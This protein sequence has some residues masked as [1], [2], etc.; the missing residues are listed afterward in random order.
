[1]GIALAN[2]RLADLTHI[3]DFKENLRTLLISALFVLLAAR[4]SP[5]DLRGLGLSSV[6]VIALLMILIR[7]ASVAV[8]TLRSKLTWRERTFIGWMAPRGIVAAAVSSVFALR[9][10]QAGVADGGV[11]VPL[12]FA[13]I[14]AT[15]LVYGLTSPIVAHR[16]KL[17]D[18]KPQG[19]LIVGAHRAAREIALAVKA[20]GFRV[21]LVDSNA[22]DVA[23]ARLAG[24]PTYHGSIL[25]ERTIEQLDLGGIGQLLAMTPNEEVNILAVQR[26][27]PIF[28]RHGV[29]Q[30][31]AREKNTQLEGIDPRLH[32]RRL[33]HEKATLAEL[34]ARLARGH[35]VKSTKLS[36]AFTFETFRAQ[37]SPELLCLFIV[38]EGRRLTVVE[39]GTKIAPKP[40]Q[41]VVSLDVPPPTQNQTDKEVTNSEKPARTA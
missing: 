36:E 34:M 25:G 9:L 19:L 29:Y 21:L 6:V 28:G 30:V 14:V 3:L 17:A 41:T 37:R 18:V 1:M 35:V 11:L 8:S 26:F 5:A 13:T 15:V 27:A 32:G 33:F 23:A 38:S 40:G 10:E 22:G 39:S 20:L 12:T 2:Q 4:I 7:P 24:L 16:L 31:V